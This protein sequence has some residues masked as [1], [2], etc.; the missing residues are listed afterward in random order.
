M[1]VAEATKYCSALGGEQL[2]VIKETDECGDFQG[3]IMDLTFSCE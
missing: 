2:K 3:G 1:A